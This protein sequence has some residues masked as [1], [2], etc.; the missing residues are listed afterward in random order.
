MKIR[1]VNKEDFLKVAEFAKNCPPLEPY[2]L[3]FYK[4]MFRYHRGVSLVAEED[5]RVLGFAFGLVAQSLPR[6][7]FFWQVG[8]SPKAQGKGLGKKLVSFFEKKAKEAGC[9]RVELTVDLGNTPSQ[10]LFESMKYKNASSQ[11]KATV[12]EEGKIA[13]KDYY[14]PGRH[15]IIYEKILL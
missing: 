3:H 7:C 14:G 8:V 5:G 9:V 12:E 1:E 15:F 10:K 13:A 2:P 6:T 4:I 11:E